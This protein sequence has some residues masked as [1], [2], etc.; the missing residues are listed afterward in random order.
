[1]VS[2]LPASLLARKMVTKLSKAVLPD[3]TEVSRTPWSFPRS[4]LLAWCK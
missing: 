2:E 4:V 3:T 1:M